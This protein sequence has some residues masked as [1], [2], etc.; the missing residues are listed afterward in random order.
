M[1]VGIDARR[2]IDLRSSASAE[3]S[4][5]SGSRWPSRLI[6]VRTTLIGWASGVSFAMRT[7]ESR[8]EA[9][10]DRMP[11]SSSLKAASSESFGL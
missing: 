2:R 6:A 8:T 1:Q 9:G 3:L 10:I 11:T 5:Q 4:S 7:I